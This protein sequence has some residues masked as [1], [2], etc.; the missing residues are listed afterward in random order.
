MKRFL[1]TLKDKWPEYLLEII[2]LIVGI[3]GAFA[4]DN[5]NERL[6]NNEQENIYLIDLKS[7]IQSDI[8][9][10]DYFIKYNSDIISSTDTIRQILEANANLAESE[11]LHFQKLHFLLWRETYFIPEKTT[12]NQIEGSNGSLQLPNKKLRDRLFRYYKDLAQFENSHEISNR[13]YQHHYI[14]PS[15]GEAT[16]TS[17][18][19]F[20]SKALSEK[21]PEFSLDRLKSSQNYLFSLQ[22]KT[23]LLRDQVD[24][25]SSFKKQAE[26]IL[27]LI[28]AELENK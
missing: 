13:L 24:Y 28:D 6:N 25:Y 19:T 9:T 16:L 18:N 23:G 11:I 22:T 21:L 7:D 27:S 20:Y 5:W 4:L 2:V 26:D 17:V 15:M 8:E 1:T 3:Y 12:I 14:S 10:L